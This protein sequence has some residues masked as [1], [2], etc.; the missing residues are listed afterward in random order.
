MLIWALAFVISC[1]DDSLDPLNMSSVKKGSILALRGT[2]L[3]NLYF[4]GKPGYEV[5]PKIWTGDETFAFDAEY[6]SEDPT[7]LA[8]FDIFVLK[9]TVPNGS[10]TRE[11]LLNVPFSEFQTTDDYKGPW[12]SVSI[13][14]EDILDVLGLDSSDPD[15]A[16]DILALYPN[17]INIESDL[18]LTDGTKVLSSQLVASGLYQSNQFY[19]AQRLNIAVTDYCSYDVN[20][21]AGTYDATE[22]SEFF[23]GYGPYDVTFTKDAVTANKFNID[24]WY[25]SGIPIYIVFTPSVD[26]VTQVVTAPEQEYTTAGGAVRLIQG[27]GTYNSCKKELLLNFTY[28]SKATGDVLD[29]F[30]WSLKQQ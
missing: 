4:Q 16:T 26:V 7:T 19:P 11:S 5:F 20:D 1:T 24:N 18:N 23:G 3:T 12:V 27:S 2:Q 25:D 22:T 10:T 9:R 8:S 29:S 6:L 14:M 15:F 17:G 13:P 28:K 30:L 21:W